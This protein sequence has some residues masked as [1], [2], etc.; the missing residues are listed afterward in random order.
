MGRVIP[1]PPPGPQAG[2]GGHFAHHDWSVTAATALDTAHSVMPV[3]VDA[4]ARDTYWGASPAEGSTCVTA[5]VEETY[6][7][8][9][10]VP[11]PAGGGGGGGPVTAA[12][13]SIVD[14]GGYYTATDVE[15]ALAELGAGG[16]GPVTA[17]GVSLADSGGYY[18]ATDVEG[19]L[20]EL[21]PHP[22]A[23]TSVHGIADTAALETQTGAQARVD[24]HVGDAT[25]AHAASAV[26]VADTAGHFTATDVEG[27]LAELAAASGGGGE[28][29]AD[30]HIAD[31]VDAHDA[32][33][34]S[35]ADTGGY[36]TATDVEGALAELAM[37]G[38]GSGIGSEGGTVTGTLNLYGR[39]VVGDADDDVAR[40]RS[41][42]VDPSQRSTAL[43]YTS[44]QLT[45]V[46]ESVG[47]TTVRST[48]LTYTSGQLTQVQETVD[49]LTITTTLTY[50][51]GSL[52]G[53]S[54]SVA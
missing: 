11:T 9:A 15:G 18:T 21:G 29:I 27:A 39:V 38:A 49:G 31:T 45:G 44:G 35:V 30:A 2:M 17:A 37:L 50:T 40:V 36:L 20:A 51:S 5:G 16:G 42:I 48:T 1:T 53:V 28:P 6:L 10:W 33:A 46:T 32:S 19:A 7:G 4:A 41:L 12:D 13:V 3:H 25:A 47:A 52:T 34:I 24:A 14:T 22:A 8:G 43:T 26:S 23:T 54:R